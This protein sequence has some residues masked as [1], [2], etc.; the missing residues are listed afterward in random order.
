MSGEASSHCRG[1]TIK[2]ELRLSWPQSLPD[3]VE[4]IGE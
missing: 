4:E 2:L 3:L 1:K